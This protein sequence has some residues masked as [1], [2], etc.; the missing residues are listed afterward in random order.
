MT[1]SYRSSRLRY[2]VSILIPLALIYGLGSWI[3]ISHQRAAFLKELELVEKSIMAMESHLFESTLE[4]YMADGAILT[5][6]CAQTLARETDK[7]L[8][9]LKISEAFKA[10][11]RHHKIYDQLRFIDPRGNER[12]R[13]NWN[14]EEGV[15]VTPQN[16]LQNKANRYYFIKGMV[17]PKGGV[18]L[19]ALDLNVE[20]GKVE[21]PYKP[22]VRMVYPVEPENRPMAGVMV[23]NLLGQSL[24]D[25]LMEAGQNTAGMV[26]LVNDKGQWIKGPS[27]ELEWQFMFQKP[28]RTV[29]DRFPSLWE[30]MSGTTEGWHRS[31]DGL[32]YFHDIIPYRLLEEFRPGL[33]LVNVHETWRIINFIPDYQLSPPW[34]AEI[35]G[36]V[37]SGGIILIALAWSG[38]GLMMR[39][40]QALEKL[41]AKEKELL[42]ITNSVR[43]AIVRVDDTGRA[44]FWND[45]AERMFG[46]SA[47]DII[48]KDIHEFITPEKLRPE[49]TEGLKLF[50]RTGTGKFIGDLREVETM[51]KDG[52]LFPAELN[53]SA[54]RSGSRWSAVGV[55]RDISHRKAIEK[56]IA[57]REQQLK[58]FIKHTPAAV[59]MFDRQIC[60]IAASDSWYKD[61]GITGQKIIGKSHYE[62]FPEI[63]G[64]AEW[65]AIHQRCLKGEV[66]KRDEDAFERADGSTDW[67]RWEVRPWMDEAGT[68]G[69]II[70]FT[71]VITARKKIEAQLKESE[72]RLR[73]AM[74]EA[75]HPAI[76]H[77]ETGDIILINQPWLRLSGY[78]RA[79]ISTV[80]DWF[81]LAYA[82]KAQDRLAKVKTLYRSDNTMGRGET[83]IKTA[84]NKTRD[85]EIST[86]DMGRLS[87][88]CRVMITMAVD[89]TE[90]K[91]AESEV[92][93]LNRE[94]EARV[95]KRTRRLEELVADIREKERMVKLLGDVASTANTATSSDQ[96]LETTLK[97]ITAY[98]NWPVGH[99]YQPAKADEGMLESSR[100]WHVEDE[101]RYREFMTVTERTRLK[102]GEG[103]P[104]R[105]YER[106]QAVW[107]EDV[108][109]DDNFPRAESL[110]AASVRGAFAFP[111]PIREEVVAVMEFFSSKITPPDASILEMVGE[112]GKQLGYVIER[113]RIERAREES[114]G[115]F[116]GIFDHSSQF[117]GLVSPEGIIL[118]INET[119]LSMVT[120]DR[121]DILGQRLWE[122]PWWHHSK[123][124]PQKN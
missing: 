24:I 61:Y 5:D 53:L 103:L 9:F 94:L 2:F 64:M 7:D 18:Y 15:W 31:K 21:H 123:T 67:L 110:S 17:Q 118:Q 115:K 74:E 26:L 82:G 84:Q 34:L 79:Q 112:V 49:A 11:A 32:F 52:K 92:I 117:M 29:A 44:L 59:A 35:Y 54:I 50:S 14:P 78:S 16:S 121:A 91:K 99:V 86:T 93:A 108:T 43:D 124:I 71:E 85:W 109:R 37:F 22:M 120:T 46:F 80:E 1:K 57:L 116:R 65:K 88:G 106:G 41:A 4:G 30:E 81:S 68:P 95:Q 107:V 20:Q 77:K 39:R 101:D 105:V 111:V 55:I 76:I 114:E 104:G 25:T 72:R 90:R 36:I 102:P 48:G 19:S 6:L 96:A 12:V 60:Y 3:I 89:V 40:R 75:P 28:P 58:T 13:V 27:P 63:E 45:S 8:A 33:P 10:Y 51:G 56:T 73:R 98:T 100:I 47:A 66:I 23:M 62:I 83:V 38:A 70:M 122:S 87:D 97:L 69:G 113:K 42:T 119:A